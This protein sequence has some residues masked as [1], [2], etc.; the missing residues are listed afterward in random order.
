M[1]PLMGATGLGEIIEVF[2]CTRRIAVYFLKAH[3]DLKLLQPLVQWR[4][5]S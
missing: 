4:W 2:K 3:Y 5:G 1:V